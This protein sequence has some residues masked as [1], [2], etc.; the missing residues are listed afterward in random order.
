MKTKALFLLIVGIC[1]AWAGSAIAAGVENE[2]GIGPGLIGHWAFDDLTD[3]MI[4]DAARV[5]LD[6]TV[7]GDVSLEDGVF[8]TAA[9]FNGR[10]AIRIKAN[11]AFKNLSAIT[12]SAW[13]S[14]KELSG[15]REIFRKEDGDKRILFS[16]QNNGRILSLGL[17]V[18]GSGYE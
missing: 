3:G 13:V 8:A 9:C 16:F 11:E 2:D 18:E 5:G 15:Y 17:N 7:R 6:A 10:H 14:P 12:I 1:V 4:R